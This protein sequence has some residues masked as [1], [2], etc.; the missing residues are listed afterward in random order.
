MSPTSSVVTIDTFIKTSGIE[1]WLFSCGEVE[2]V[3]E[4]VTETTETPTKRP[5]LDPDTRLELRRLCW[6]TMFGQELVKLTIMDLV[7]NLFEIISPTI[8][9]NS[10]M[11]ILAYDINMKSI[12]HTHR[13]HIHFHVIIK[14]G[15]V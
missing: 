5:T 12:D 13:V 6:E 9:N 4:V 8:N 14:L 11:N 3:P 7:S 2:E 15:S 10:T 1:W